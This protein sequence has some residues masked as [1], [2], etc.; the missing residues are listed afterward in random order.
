MIIKKIAAIFIVTFCLLSFMENSCLAQAVLNYGEY[1][2][3]LSDREKIIY[4]IG[5]RD[6]IAKG[7]RDCVE[8]FAYSLKK[9]K[10]PQLLGADF[11]DEYYWYDKFFSSHRD[12]IIKVVSDLYKDPINSFI[13]IS[14]MFFLARRKLNGESIESSLKELREKECIECGL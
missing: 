2:N 4:F 6:G 3:S 7:G 9:E 12:A 8:W 5:V 10:E 11:I 14:D 1:W 13:Y